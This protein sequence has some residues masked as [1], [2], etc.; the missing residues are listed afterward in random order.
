MSLSPN[1]EHLM[2]VSQNVSSDIETIQSRH[3]EIPWYPYGSMANFD[4]LKPLLGSVDFLFSGDRRIADIGAADGHI[5]Y[6]FERAGNR[7]DIYDNGPT[8]YNGLR[9]ARLLKQEL[10]SN[11][12]IFEK[13]LDSQFILEGRYDLAIFLGIFYHLKNP[14]YALEA[15]GQHSDY[16]LF[17]TRVCR[18]YKTGSPDISGAALAYLLDPDESNNDATNYWIFTMEGLNRIFKRTGWRLIA[19]H[20]VG[21]TIASNPQDQ[22]ADERFM[23]I[24]TRM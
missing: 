14:Y 3:N 10:S 17:S 20:T 2:R 21:D 6:T 16:M 5:A 1:F 15:I 11:I 19:G 4:H 8:N 12:N 13:D 7:C 18:H 23:G 9:G 24:L 22:F